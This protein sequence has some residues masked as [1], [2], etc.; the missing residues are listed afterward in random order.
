M[1]RK[2]NRSMTALPVAYQKLI[3]ITRYI[4]AITEPSELF[5]KLIDGAVEMTGA[6]RGY[7]LLLQGPLEKDQ[8]LGGLKPVAACRILPE[9]LKS[10]SFQASSTAIIK[11]V[12]EKKR[13]YWTGGVSGEIRSQSMELFGLRSIVCE[14]LTIHQKVLGVLYLDSKINR[15]FSDDHREILP[16]FAAQAAICLENI[17]LIEEREEALKR[18]HAEQARALELQ[19]YKETVS[20][21]MSI[22]SHDLKG[23]LTVMKTGLALLKRTQPS[24]SQQEVIHDLEQAIARASRLVSTYLDI[25]KLEDGHT[26]SLEKKPIRLKPILEEELSL[27]LAPMEAHRRDAFEFDV[28][29]SEETVIN[30]D[31]SR[32]SQIFGNLIE[33]AVK[34]SPKG[35]RIQLRHQARNGHDHIWIRDQGLGM[36]EEGRKKLFAR[37]VRLEQDRAIRGT[38]LG[39]FIV[40]RL[41]ESHGGRIDVESSE[42]RGTTF[43]V[44]LPRG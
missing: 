33:N 23:P 13:A 12:E 11:A 38:G 26:L 14:P 22:A 41:V 36:S 17:R 8:P 15:K 25:Q 4:T 37:F 5:Q 20:S 19:V 16:S 30:G 6:E 31:P 2:E 39:L 21:F 40:R 9:E 3:E 32:L 35:G 7:L 44:V 34:Y 10:E 28:G 18:E 24:D 29:V 42:G 1:D 43:E 27:V